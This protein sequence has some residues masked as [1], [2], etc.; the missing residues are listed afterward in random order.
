MGSSYV[1]IDDASL[2]AVVLRFMSQHVKHEVIVAGND[3]FYEMKTWASMIPLASKAHPR[4][5]GDRAHAARALGKR[6][7]GSNL[8]GSTRLATGRTL[9]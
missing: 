6:E 9:V 3:A 8:A 1:G 2:G 4:A 5:F 7:H